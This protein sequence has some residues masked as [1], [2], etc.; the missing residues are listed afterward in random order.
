M[1]RLTILMIALILPG[2][3]TTHRDYGLFLDGIVNDENGNIIEGVDVLL[4]LSEDVYDVLTP[5]REKTFQTGADGKY[6]FFYI[7]HSPKINY[8]LTFSKSGYIDKRIEGNE[9]SKKE[10][11]TMTS[12]KLSK[13]APLQTTQLR[14]TALSG[15]PLARRYV[16]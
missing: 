1:I 3:V 12:N 2:C 11:V 5:V 8:V 10:T 7:T 4:E 15:R 9:M 6:S 16:Y 13:F 14:G